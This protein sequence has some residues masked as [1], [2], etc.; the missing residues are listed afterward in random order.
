MYYT[1]IKKRRASENTREENVQNM[2]RRRVFSA[3]LE[4]SQ[5][6]GVFYHSV[7]HGLGFLHLLYGIEVMWRKTIK[8]AFLCLYCDK[9]WVFDQSERLI[10]VFASH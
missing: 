2:N 5:M 7:I 9:T 4:Y 10:L 1:V 3:F 8:Q 6:F